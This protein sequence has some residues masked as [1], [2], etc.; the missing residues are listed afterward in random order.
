MPKRK[1]PFADPVRNA[2]NAAI[3][4]PKNPEM[5]A[6]QRLLAHDAQD[7]DRHRAA[8]RAP[9]RRGEPEERVQQDEDDDR[10]RGIEQ[11]GNPAHLLH[12]RRLPLFVA[13]VSGRV[14]LVA[15]SSG[16]SHER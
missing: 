8:D 6:L 9:D 3:A 7:G 11:A 12:Q 15:G 1:N 16:F 2:M 13:P 5:A 14:L 10:H 4:T